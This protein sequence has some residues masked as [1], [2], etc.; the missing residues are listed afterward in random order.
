MR[1]SE[2]PGLTA[3][4]E[5]NAK[6]AVE[7]TCELCSEYFALPLLLIHRISRRLYREM[8]RDPST[9]ILVV[10]GPCHEHIHRLPMRVKDQREIV[11]RRPYVVR[12]DLRRALGYIPR[13]YSPPKTASTSEMYEEYFYHFPPGSFRLGG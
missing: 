2:Y 6:R 8:V 7:G 9:R 13:P 12:Q 1:A 10:C 3:A 11:R 4:Q 5:K